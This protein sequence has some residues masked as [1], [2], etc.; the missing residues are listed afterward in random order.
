MNKVT[1]SADWPKQWKVER[2]T[3]IGKIPQPESEDDLRPIALTYFFSK[4]MEHFVVMWL[5]TFIGDKMDF[6]QYGGTKGNSVSHYLIEFINFILYNQDAREPTAVLAC[7]VDFAKAFNRQDHNILVTKLSDMG[8]PAWLLRIVISFLKDRK[9]IVR[10]K[11]KASNPKWLPGGGPQGTL[12]GLLLFLVLINDV[13]F[14]N[15]T[16]NL[17]E[18]ITC[19]KRIASM[20][21]IH[22]KYVDDLSIAETIKMKEMLNFAD[23]QDRPQPDH[24][25]SQTGHTLKPE[26][27]RVYNQ[28][29]QISQYATENGMR[30]NYKKTK[31]I[32]FNPCVS[33]DFLPNFELDGHEIEHVDEVRLLGLVLRSDLSWCSNTESLVERC[34]K[35][36]WFLRR[37]KSLGACM[38]DILDLYEEHVRCI[39]EYAAPVWHSSLKGEDRLKLERVQKSALHIILGE[40]YQSYTSALKMTGTKTLFERRRLLCLKFARKSLKSNKFKTWFKPNTNDLATRQEQSKFCEVYSRLDRFE[41]SPISYLT[42]LLNN[43]KE[44]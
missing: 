42:Q 3:P 7:L 36:L 12:L 29:D 17:G 25:H 9:M 5:L 31:F 1:Q 32:L 15:Q 39:L 24:F 21:E 38:Q 16:Q 26:Q 23:V 43:D 20:N 44:N 33:K 41:K 34:N 6:R 37:L 28:L 40:R 14:P 4:V 13:G 10:Y 2:T 30:L 11:G 27:S 35:K 8:V 19:K 18:V 22:L